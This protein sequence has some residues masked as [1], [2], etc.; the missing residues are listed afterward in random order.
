MEKENVV[1]EEEK[2]IDDNGTMEEVVT[3]DEVKKVGILTK[4]KDVVSKNW[5]GF[6]AGGL[7]ALGSI[8]VLA[9]ANSQNDS[10]DSTE[11]ISIDADS[12]NLIGTNSTTMDGSASSN[13][14]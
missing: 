13:E 9:L 5:K 11:F 10:D 7:T 1:V 14:E 12:M 4:A 8:V 3:N 2:V 6:V